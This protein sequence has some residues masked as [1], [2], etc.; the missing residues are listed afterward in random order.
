[1]LVTFDKFFEKQTNINKKENKSIKCEVQT[2][3]NNL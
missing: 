2:N 3:F 1:M